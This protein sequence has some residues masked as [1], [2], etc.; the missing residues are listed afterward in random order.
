[1][2]RISSTAQHFDVILARIAA[3]ERIGDVLRGL[4]IKR[5]TFEAFL[6]QHH[7]YAER[8]QAAKPMV[9]PE[10]IEARFAE[11][12]KRIANGATLDE[13]LEHYGF[14]NSSFH[15]LMGL[16]RDLKAQFVAA[17]E[18]RQAGPNRRGKP[19][20]MKARPTWTDEHFERALD[21][22][23]NC[24]LPAYE[25]ALGGDLPGQIVVNGKARRDPAYAE[26]LRAAVEARPRPVAYDLD[27][28]IEALR[29]GR[30][31]SY[32]HALR[33][34]TGQTWSSVVLAKLRAHPEFR[35]AIRMFRIVNAPKPKSR[36]DRPAGQ[37]HAALLKI[38]AYAAAWKMFRRA[39]YDEQQDAI[40]E[41]ILAVLEGE[42]E[43]VA[44]RETKRR[45]M[46]KAIGPRSHDVSLHK[47]LSD[48][49]DSFTLEDTIANDDGILF[50]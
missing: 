47:Q 37:L 11:L 3:G 8:Y 28:G 18:A 17:T 9:G 36:D 22:I 35:E 5:P 48:G 44:S 6:R 15:K 13:A 50:Y 1:L 45:M 7:D 16:R 30:K 39:D 31:R 21:V 10:A 14:S 33:E 46:A 38:P 27:A 40:G 32:R 26:R 12:M 20:T 2:A 42:V 29:K 34:A 49:D 41:F 23:R 19:A 43:P 4:G 24:D 25:D